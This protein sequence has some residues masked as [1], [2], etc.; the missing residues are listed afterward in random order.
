[1]TLM[2]L[3]YVIR[4]SD[5]VL[6]HIKIGGCLVDKGSAIWVNGNLTVQNSVIERVEGKRGTAVIQGASNSAISIQ[7]VVFRRNR[8]IRL[9][10]GYRGGRLHISMSIFEDNAARDGDATVALDQF[11]QLEVRDTVFRRQRGR[12]LLT[13]DVAIATLHNCSFRKNNAED[14]GS[15]FSAYVHLA[16]SGGWRLKEVV[17][18]FRGKG[19]R[20]G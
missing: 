14:S 11:D 18:M 8:A 6:D 1:M 17:H 9:I 12:S 2:T 20:Q 13:R 7:N 16:S 15:T 19:R 5:V 3:I 4:D 10:G